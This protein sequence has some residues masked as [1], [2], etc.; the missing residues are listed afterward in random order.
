VN[1][2]HDLGG[3]MGYGPIAPEPDEPVFHAEWERRV[4]GMVGAVSSDWSIDADRS[5]CEAMSP[6]AYLNSSYYEHWLHGLET[7]LVANGFVGAE[8]LAKG[9]VNLPRKDVA[10]PTRA[11]DVW[12]HVTEPGRYLRPAPAPA[13]FKIGDKVRARNIHPETH[14][15][16]PRYV[17][18][19]IGEITMVHGCHVFPDS[20]ATGIGEDPQWLYAVT[21]TSRELWGRDTADTVT[22]DLWE[23]Y[24]EPA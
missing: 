22:L 19:R 3:A 5:A 23:P 16:L 11:S 14:T 6:V 7:L 4:F 13:R 20:N 2:A 17:R 12:R 1:G 10:A 18:D 15:R 8:E 9:K 24:L 21:F